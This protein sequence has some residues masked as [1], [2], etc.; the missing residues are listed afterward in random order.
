MTTGEKIRAARK[1]AGLTQK[2]LGELCGIAE[3]TIRRYELGKLKPKLETLLKIAKPLGF[4]CIELCGDDTMT[5]DDGGFALN[6]G[7]GAKKAELVELI[8]LIV[9]E[10]DSFDGNELSQGDFAQIFQRAVQKQGKREL[11]II[12]Q[13]SDN[14]CECAEAAP[15]S[16]LN[17]N[18]GT[19]T[20]PPPEGS[21]GPQEGE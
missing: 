13:S 7:G 17:S 14:A 6:F 3:P 16:T 21:E 4:H 5:L 15:Q 19:D 18:E 11:K 9:D 20:T 8:K 2:Q 10:L 1:K 12:V